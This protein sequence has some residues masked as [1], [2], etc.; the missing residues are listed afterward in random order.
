MDAFL[1]LCRP[2]GWLVIS[3][4]ESVPLET[5][6][7]FNL[8]PHCQSRGEE[9]LLCRMCEGVPMISRSDGKHFHLFLA[10]QPV[11]YPA[12]KKARRSDL[13]SVCFWYAPLQEQT[14][15]T[16]FSRCSTREER[17]ICRFFQEC[18]TRCGSISREI[19]NRFANVYAL[20][21]R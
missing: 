18:G 20:S 4:T 10:D 21:A 1:D 13:V 9:G 3:Q 19:A 8:C 2:V 14:R 6:R 12:E 7:N 17:G 11:P 15:D 16:N 5:F